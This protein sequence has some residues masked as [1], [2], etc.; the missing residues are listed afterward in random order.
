MSQGIKYIE[1]I[2]L[3]TEPKV[4]I[5]SRSPSEDDNPEL[6]PGLQ[7]RVQTQ[8]AKELNFYI[9]LEI[10]ELEKGGYIGKVI[11][12]QGYQGPCDIIYPGEYL[13]LEFDGLTTND[14]VRFEQKHIR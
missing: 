14:L 10:T 8:N 4:E 2:D 9:V 6:R 5:R 11:G 12:Q 7:V 1:L 13:Q 3:S